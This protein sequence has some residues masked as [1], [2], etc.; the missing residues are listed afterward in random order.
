MSIKK[1]HIVKK[2]FKSTSFGIKNGKSADQA[3][4]R[5]KTIWI[6]NTVYFL[7]Y[8]IKNA[9]NNVNRNRLKNTFSRYI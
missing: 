2:V 6:S 8:D 9:F 7:V 3:F 1:D 4:H 5:I